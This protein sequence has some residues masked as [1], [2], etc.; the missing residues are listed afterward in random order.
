M[1]GISAYSGG[2]ELL[3]HLNSLPVHITDVLLRLRRRAQ[4]YKLLSVL[5]DFTERKSFC[6]G[7]EFASR[8][9]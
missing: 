4:G 3:A 9:S 6:F 7:E 5:G 1:P 2:M 8:F